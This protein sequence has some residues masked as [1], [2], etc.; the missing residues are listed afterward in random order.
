MPK[1]LPRIPRAVVKAGV[2]TYL[3]VRLMGRGAVFSGLAVMVGVAPLSGIA[4]GQI[5]KYWDKSQVKRDKRMGQLNELLSSI[6]LVKLNGWEAGFGQH[7]AKT[8]ALEMAAMW[9][10]HIF[11]HVFDAVQQIVPVATLLT[12]FGV[13]THL[14]NQLTPSV[15]FTALALLEEIRQP[16]L[17][18]SNVVSN[19]VRAWA[20][21]S[22]VSS[23]LSAEQLDAH[24][25]QR[26][27]MDTGGGGGGG[28]DRHKPAIS[29]AGGEFA[30]N[31]KPAL[32][33]QGDSDEEG[34]GEGDGDATGQ[35]G[36]GDGD[37][38]GKQSPALD[39]A[40]AAPTTFRL[41]NV[42]FDVPAGALVAVV[43]TVG[44]GKSSLLQALAQGDT[45][46]LHCH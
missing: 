9:L 43:G 11:D 4:L 6:K 38:D 12:I 17:S 37:N 3:L 10:C 16:I 39:G 40:G 44:S 8:R 15:T 22:R 19:L 23:F 26:L 42:T 5:D 14:G 25:V 45:V 46:I 27:A 2:G 21:I 33:L 7:I 30:W 1:E 13:Y 24:A 31:P 18:V 28:A 29:V 41:E 36:D 35:G 34:E 20:A 32:D